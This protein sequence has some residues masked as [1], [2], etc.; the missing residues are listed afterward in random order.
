MHDDSAHNSRLESV[1]IDFPLLRLPV[2]NGPHFQNISTPPSTKQVPS[3]SPSIDR[4]PTAVITTRKTSKADWRENKSDRTRRSPYKPFRLDENSWISRDTR[5]MDDFSQSRQKRTLTRK[6]SAR[7]K[8]GPFATA[9]KFSAA[10]R[11]TSVQLG[12]IACVGIL[13][14]PLPLPGG[15]F[16]DSKSVIGSHYRRLNSCL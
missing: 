11:C 3:V 10:G 5:I 14:C 15:G 16:F 9:R 1:R 13:H 4:R 12:L 8:K 7:D 6:A 2:S